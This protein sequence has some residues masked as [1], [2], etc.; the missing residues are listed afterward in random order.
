MNQTRNRVASPTRT[1][2]DLDPLLL[3]H[4]SHPGSY[5]EFRRDDDLLVSPSW[6]PVWDVDLTKRFR[7]RRYRRKSNVKS[8]SRF[9]SL[10][11]PELKQEEAKQS[12]ART[13]ITENDQLSSDASMNTSRRLVVESPVRGTK[14]QDDVMTPTELIKVLEEFNGHSEAPPGFLEIGKDGRSP[15]SLMLE[16]LTDLLCYINVNEAEDMGVSWDAVY[17]VVH[18][19]V[20]AKG[21]D[22]CHKPFENLEIIDDCSHSTTSSVSSCMSTKLLDSLMI[23]GDNTF[24]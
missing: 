20:P 16:E 7:I 6:S 4:Q 22:P 3:R 10:K 8:V 11:R 24:H 12:P 2:S 5:V 21:D 9:S 14:R 18:R 19:Q 13:E 17:N 23:S 1:R 15:P